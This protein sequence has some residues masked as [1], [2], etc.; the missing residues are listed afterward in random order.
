MRVYCTGEVF[1]SLKSG[2]RSFYDLIKFKLVLQKTG[3]S[4]RRGALRDPF[5]NIT[6]LPDMIK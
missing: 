5:V 3:G 6:L 4:N 2:L 1:F